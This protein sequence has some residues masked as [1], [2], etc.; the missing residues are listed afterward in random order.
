[1]WLM[2]TRQ[3][4]K[5]SGAS[6]RVV[7]SLVSVGTEAPLLLDRFLYKE[8]PD[9]FHEVSQ[10]QLHFLNCIDLKTNNLISY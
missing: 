5:G 8:N 4:E 9:C 6:W 3:A 10:V 2:V 7:L 1:M